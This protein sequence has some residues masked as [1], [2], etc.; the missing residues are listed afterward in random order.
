MKFASALAPPASSRKVTWEDIQKVVWLFSLISML[1][2]CLHY[3]CQFSSLRMCY[4][5]ELEILWRLWSE[6]ASG[7]HNS[8]CVFHWDQTHDCPS[9][10][11]FFT[12]PCSLMSIVS[13]RIVSQ[14]MK[15]ISLTSYALSSVLWLH[16]IL[17]MPYRFEEH[18]KNDLEIWAP[19][20]WKEPG[21][22]RMVR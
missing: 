4:L 11:H 1:A 21:S 5:V 18:Y 17:T 3:Q 19:M 20:C 13:Q 15:D 8:L 6:I 2:W 10:W 7:I 16:P 22:R 12:L 9:T 14:R